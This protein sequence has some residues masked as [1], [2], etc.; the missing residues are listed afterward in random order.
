MK[1]K[2]FAEFWGVADGGEKLTDMI[3]DLSPPFFS[4]TNLHL[5]SCMQ[6]KSVCMQEAREAGHVFC[7]KCVCV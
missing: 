7:K 6:A 3:F 2:I 1:I 5:V 4:M